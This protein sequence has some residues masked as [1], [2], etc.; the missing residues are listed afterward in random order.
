MCPEMHSRAL[1]RRIAW[2]VMIGYFSRGSPRGRTTMSAPRREFLGKLAALGAAA[3]LPA[4]L[5]AQGAKASRID[6]HHHLM[7]PGFLDEVAGRRAGS[8]FKWS[9]QMSLE[10]MDKIGIALSVLSLIQPS[11]VITDLEKGRRIARVSN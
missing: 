5:V 6:V 4:G 8:T 10:D 2:T 7:Y 1:P 11:P 9:P 3:A